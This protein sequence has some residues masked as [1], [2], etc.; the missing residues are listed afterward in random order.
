M[1]P[2][3]PK[4]GLYWA[5]SASI[6]ANCGYLRLETELISLVQILPPRG[7]PRERSLLYQHPEVSTTLLRAAAYTYA[8]VSTRP[9]RRCSAPVL[10][11]AAARLPWYN[12]PPY[13][14]QYPSAES[15]AK[16]PALRYK[17]YGPGGA[18]PLIWTTDPAGAGSPRS[19]RGFWAP[20]TLGQYRT[21]RS[22][23]VAACTLTRHVR[24]QHV[25]EHSPRLQ[26]RTARWQQA[27]QRG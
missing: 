10:R 17:V 3:Q 6:W 16:D 5:K 26:F 9:L 19:G 18:K 8:R 24:V 15:S 21:P 2:R 23:R 22:T 14:R 4:L 7:R 11:P 12:A 20:H 1:P 27:A 25:T 13:K